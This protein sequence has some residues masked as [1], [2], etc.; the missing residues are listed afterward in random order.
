MSENMNHLVNYPVEVP[1][2]AIF[3]KFDGLISTAYGELREDDLSIAEAEE[4]A[5]QLAE[6][7]LNAAFIGPLEK[8]KFRPVAHV[9]LK[10]ETIY[11]N[12]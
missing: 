1:V 3:T 8:T 9:R 11:H 10:G 5:P 6:E 4:K 2:I 7:K 12:L